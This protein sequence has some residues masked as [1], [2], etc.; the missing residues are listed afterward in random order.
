MDQTTQMVFAHYERMVKAELPEAKRIAHEII[1]GWD[2][3]AKIAEHRA[4]VDAATSGQRIA[5]HML[6]AAM[7]G[8]QIKQR[9]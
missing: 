1:N 9:K 6:N 8:Q 2:F 7:R 5:D 3:D 4:G